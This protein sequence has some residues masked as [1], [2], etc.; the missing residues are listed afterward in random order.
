MATSLDKFD[1]LKHI[2]VY[3][4]GKTKLGRLLSNFADTPFICEDGPFQS[5]EGYWYWLS[6]LD[7]N[8]RGLTG[9]D[10]KD[11]GRNMP[12][13]QWLAPEEFER[14]IVA[15]LV[16]KIYQRNDIKAMLKDSTLPFKHYYVH[17]GKTT[18]PEDNKWVLVALEAIR[19]ELKADSGESD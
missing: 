12:G 16:A 13:R 10:A 9:Y 19:D 8:L 15:A 14:R 7:D 3:S 6:T 2:N 5:V 11:Y 17:N 1:G 18:E 4:K